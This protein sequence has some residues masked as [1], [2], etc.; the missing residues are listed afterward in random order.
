M[1]C[2]QCS[3]NFDPKWGVKRSRPPRY[4]SRECMY[5]AW[6]IQKAERGVQR[7]KTCPVCSQS[8]V[9]LRGHPGERQRYCSLQCRSIGDSGPNH[10]Q[11]KGGS[12]SRGYRYISVNRK[13]IAEHRYVMSE[14]LG[15]PLERREIVHHRDHDRSNNTL[16]NLE[17]MP[18][19]AGHRIR[20]ATPRTDI[21]KVCTYCHQSKP[22]TDFSRQNRPGKDAHRPRCKDCYRAL[23]ATPE[24]RV[25]DAA[26]QR[27]YRERKRS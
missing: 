1:I 6:A 9:P 14:H 8:Y 12:I 7:L 18:S 16:S 11:W 26:R 10:P 27:R 2:E 17:L 5:R 21:Y 20:H 13:R 19:I 4:C 15:R 22:R 25:K 3:K 23:R 24:Q